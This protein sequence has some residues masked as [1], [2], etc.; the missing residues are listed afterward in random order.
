MLPDVQRFLPVASTGSIEAVELRDKDPKRYHG[1][2]VLKA[3]NNVNEVIAKALVGANAFDQTSIDLELQRLD[4]TDN[5]SNLGA[6]ATLG[7]SLAVAKAAANAVVCR[8]SDMS[9]AYPHRFFRC[10]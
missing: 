9:E 6:N 7:V 2:G 8:S 4:G 5:K 1:K 3:I 10:R